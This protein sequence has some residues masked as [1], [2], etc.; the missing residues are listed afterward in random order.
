[1]IVPTPLSKFGF[2]FFFKQQQK[3]LKMQRP[4]GIAQTAKYPMRGTALN[5]KRRR[6]GKK[7][8]KRSKI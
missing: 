7:I 8:I 2:S 6:R 3:K 1:L 4:K 5:L